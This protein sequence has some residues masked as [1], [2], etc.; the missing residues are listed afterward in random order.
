MIERDG[1]P[2]TAFALGV[3]IMSIAATSPYDVFA[4]GGWEREALFI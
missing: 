2:Y 1:R 3:E 4:V